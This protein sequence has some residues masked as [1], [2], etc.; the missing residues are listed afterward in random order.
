MLPRGGTPFGRLVK[1]LAHRLCEQDFSF[2]LLNLFCTPEFFT[3]FF[4]DA[5]MNRESNSEPEFMAGFWQGAH[6]SDCLQAARPRGAR[7]PT[8]SQARG[9]PQ[10]RA[11]P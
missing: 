8:T 5:Q 3:T 7:S 11:G 1:A 2:L 10:S 6:G 4:D 9:A